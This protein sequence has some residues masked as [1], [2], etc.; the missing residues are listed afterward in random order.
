MWRDRICTTVVLVT[1]VM[2]TLLPTV[3]HANEVELNETEAAVEETTNAT[4]TANA[5]VEAAVNETAEAPSAQEETQS[6]EA[7]AP[8]AEAPPAQ[9]VEVQASDTKTTVVYEPKTPITFPEGSG[10]ED[11]RDGKRC[12]RYSY[13]PQTG[14]VLKVTVNGTLST[15]TFGKY[16]WK[17]SDGWTVDMEAQLYA[18][19]LP[20]QNTVGK[21]TMTVDYFLN[22]SKEGTGTVTFSIVPSPVESLTYTPASTITLVK[23]ADSSKIYEYDP[24]AKSG[25][26]YNK[27]FFPKDTRLTGDKLTVKLASGTTKVYVWTKFQH[28]KGYEALGF[29]NEA[30]SND[31][32]EEYELNITSGQ[33]FNKQWKSGTHYFEITYQGAK[34]KI[35][36]TVKAQT[37]SK[38]SYTRKTAIKRSAAKA[39]T[40][41]QNMGLYDADYAKRV[42]RYNIVFYAP[43][44]A[45]GDVLKV[46]EKDGD[47]IQY[48]YNAQTQA[49]VNKIN[50]KDTI[51]RRDVIMR[52]YTA[53]EKTTKPSFPCTYKGIDFGIPFTISKT[54]QTVKAKN[55]QVRVGKKAKLNPSSSGFEESKFTF[56]SSNKRVATV[57]SKGV[58]TGKKVG[59]AKITIRAKANAVFKK[60]KAKTIV[61]KVRKA[62]PMQVSAKKKVAIMRGKKAKPIRVSKAKGKVSY[63]NVS[64]SKVAKTFKVS[65]K[66]GRVR[67]P[68][69]T[70]KGT[71]KLKVKVRAKGTK[72]Y[73][74]K[75]KTVTIKVTVR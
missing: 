57:N 10:E 34:A 37:V 3:A 32:I 24:I 50:S 36:V 23:G 38:V 29:V 51:V 17:D 69:K 66:T 2:A 39:I 21:H 71:Y 53:D 20:S 11:V 31:P 41:T 22:Y 46:T 1:L 75:T 6:A 74:T 48:V 72:T 42:T 13:W 58:V 60:S 9:P 59:N 33:S 67:V 40:Y 52:S 8:E 55:K 43:E 70:K 61:V 19:L 35:P 62:N 27:Y 16:S 45:A 63:A 12:Y 47:V 73:A 49:F 18:Y 5:T 56:A 15:Y 30:N 26:T 25:G 64:S 44:P 68:K 14:D 65:S 54:K 7:K 28:P 4:G